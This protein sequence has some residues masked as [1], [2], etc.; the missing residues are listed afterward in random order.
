MEIW[1][2]EKEN[3]HHDV[4]KPRGFIIEYNEVE[5]KDMAQGGGAKIPAR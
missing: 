2:F 3:I 1:P 5:V 4:S